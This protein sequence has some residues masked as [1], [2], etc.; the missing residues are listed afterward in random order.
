MSNEI[1]VK[2]LAIDVPDIKQRLADAGC[3]SLG[4]EFQQNYMFDYAN[5][6]LYEEQDGSYIRLRRSRYF[7]ERS[8]TPETTVLT[9]KKTLSRDRFK[10]AQETETPVGDFEQTRQFLMLLDLRQVRSD[11]KFRQSYR[12]EDILFEIDE[13]AGLPP[14]LEVEAASEERVAFGLSL[15]GLSLQDSTTMN[16]REVLATYKIKASNLHFADF[17]RDILAEISAN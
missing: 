3:Q 11:E 10:I 17:G 12:F 2:V 1:E 13:W 7:P 5:R 9:Y 15:L 16:L 6:R 14:Y 8:D 4:Q